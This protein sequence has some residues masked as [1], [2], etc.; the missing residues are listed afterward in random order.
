[1]RIYYLD[2]ELS[3]KEIEFVQ[4]VLELTEPIHQVRI[5]HILPAPDPDG[6]HRGRP[7]LDDEIL[8]ASAGQGCRAGR[9]EGT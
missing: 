7:L 2:R 1:M 5:P 6:G 4:Q 8:C 9:G 3:E